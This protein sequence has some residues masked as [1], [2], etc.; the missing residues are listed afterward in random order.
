MDKIIR[1]IDKGRLT[2]GQ[3]IPS[4]R[5]LADRY[6]C[7]KDTA[8]KALI[9]LRYQKYIYAVPKSG[10]YVLE[11]DQNKKEDI[12]LA[13]TDDRHQAYEDFRLCVNETL[14]GREN[15]L[16]NY[17]SQQEGL[18]ELRQSVQRL[19]LDSAVY[20]S[21]DSLILTSGTQQALYILSQIDFPNGKETILVEQPT[22]HRI[23]DLLLNQK[24]P[25]ESI[26]RKPTGIDLKELE[27]IF[28]TGQIKFFYTIPRF[29][30][31][32]GH[33]YSRQEKE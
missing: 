7:S 32:L 15:Y 18:E 26:E 12:E 17:Y 20:T 19:L 2:R 27:R 8:Q 25:Y 10:Y 11:N 13:V 31:P 23:N 33:S 22:Y 5:K 4:V 30:Y 28:Q 14:I 3:K 29:H 1:D 6:H 21:A 16:F 24:L 9:E